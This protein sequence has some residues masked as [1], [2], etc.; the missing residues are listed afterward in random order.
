MIYTAIQIL[1]QQRKEKLQAIE[2][3]TNCPEMTSIIAILQKQINE[4]DLAI[5]ILE[6]QVLLVET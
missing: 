1:R 6:Q 5:N 4:L 2:K 3:W